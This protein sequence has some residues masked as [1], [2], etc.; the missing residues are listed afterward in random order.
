[1]NDIILDVLDAIEIAEILEHMLERLAGHDRLGV[2]E[3]SDTHGL[4]DLRT[5]VTGDAPTAADDG[6]AGVK[7]LLTLGVATECHYAHRPEFRPDC[8]ILAV[9]SY[10]KIALCGECDLR[11]SAVGKGIAPRR[12]PDPRALLEV[13]LAREARRHAETALAE[14]VRA[15]RRKGQPW[16]VL[17][18]VLGASR[19]AVQQRFGSE[20]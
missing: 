11:R 19:Q 9:V 14:A 13:V 15:A 1:M 10:G 17:G 6:P 12:L 5:D 7:D 8:A 2:L 16:S 20:G 3:V 18:A 4:H